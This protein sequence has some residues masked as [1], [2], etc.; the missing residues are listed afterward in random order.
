MGLIL[1]RLLRI[2][3]NIPHQLNWGWYHML[4]FWVPRAP[5]LWPLSIYVVPSNSNLWHHQRIMWFE[6]QANIF[7][8][9]FIWFKIYFLPIHMCLSVNILL[10][11]VYCVCRSEWSEEGMRAPSWEVTGDCESLYRCRE[12]NVCLCENSVH[13]QPLRDLSPSLRN[14]NSTTEFWFS[15]G[16]WCL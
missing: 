4:T 13:S 8:Y 11:Y 1:E 16:E 9:K 15:H 7:F 14:F 10:I 3:S 12:P 2:R 5:I 6:T